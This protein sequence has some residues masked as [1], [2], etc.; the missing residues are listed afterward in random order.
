MLESDGYT[1]TD[2]SEAMSIW[3][4]TFHGKAMRHL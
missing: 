2:G 4:A 3:E 1:Y